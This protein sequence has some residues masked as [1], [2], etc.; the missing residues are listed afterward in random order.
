MHVTMT[1]NGEPVTSNEIAERSRLLRMT[2][3]STGASVERQATEELIDE[4]LKL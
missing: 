2:S 3:H 4:K 1:V